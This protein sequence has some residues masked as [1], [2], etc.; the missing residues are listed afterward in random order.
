MNTAQ[1]KAIAI[2]V[3]LLVMLW[4]ATEM[5]SRRSEPVAPAPRLPRLA[6]TD[7]DTIAIMRGVDTVIL[8]KQSPGKWTVNGFAAETSGVNE[9]LQAVRDSG[10][11]ELV[12]HDPSSFARMGVDTAGRVVRFVGSGKTLATLF[13]GERSP[14]PDAFYL[15][16]PGDRHVYLWHGRLAELATRPVDT[17]RD[18]TIAAVAPDSIAE[19]EIQRGGTRLLL[20]KQGIKWTLAGGIPV[21][22]AAA[23]RLVESLQN[24]RATGFATPR[25]VDSLRSAR[26]SRSVVVRNPGRRELLALAFDSAAGGFWVRRESTVSRMDSWHVDQLTPTEAVLAPPTRAK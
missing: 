15:R 21:D 12:A 14:A 2:G 16:L 17:W 10:T 18:H 5:L 25:Q 8:A 22:S 26:P 20:R 11:P 3:G 19:V 9:L 23:G 13:V 24:I 1:L 4:G 6:A 7:V